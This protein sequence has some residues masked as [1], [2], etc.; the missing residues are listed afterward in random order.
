MKYY[1]KRILCTM[2]SA[3]LII[4]LAACT[5]QGSQTTQ[6]TQTTQTTAQTTTQTTTTEPMTID[7]VSFTMR[8]WDQVNWENSPL[9]L[10][11]QETFGLKLSVE[12]IDLEGYEEKFKIMFSTLNL[13]DICTW[14]GVSASDI[15]EAG[16][17]GIFADY[18]QYMDIMPNFRAICDEWYDML[19]YVTANSGALY[20]SPTYTTVSQPGYGGRGI[21]VRKDILDAAGFDYSNLES[22]DDLY[23]MF[24]VLKEGKDDQYV[25]G[26]DNNTWYI[27]SYIGVSREPGLWNEESQEWTANYMTPNCK[28]FVIFWANAFADGL[29]HPDYLNIGT[30]ELNQ[31]FYNGVVTAVCH[32]MYFLD[33]NTLGAVT[34]QE[35]THVLPP[36]YNGKKHPR[37]TTPIF[38][39]AMGRLVSGKLDEKV[40]QKIMRLNDWCYSMDGWK[41]TYLGIENED[42]IILSDDPF[43]TLALIES[44]KDK[45]PEAFKDKILTLE[46][47]STRRADLPT[48]LYGFYSLVPNPTPQDLETIADRTYAAN[49]WYA[50]PEPVV[51]LTGDELDEY[52]SLYSTID[53]YAKQIIAQMITGQLDIEAEWDKFLANLKDY[54]YDRLIELYN[55]GTQNFK[56]VKPNYQQ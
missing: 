37:P 38:D 53:D 25:I 5:P 48:N 12:I 34:E 49:G 26:R 31:H 22:L 9:D 19:P 29:L 1:W 14:R 2:I 16:D 35:W 17:R 4:G 7:E 6:P 54:G 8:S 51:T 24:T 30:S 33:N 23:E 50:K 32:G 10:Y 15:N 56:A 27:G 44:N 11:I 36:L 46:E 40:T 13:P 28:D 3:M 18:Y 47:S 21:G 41:R 52:N 43:K 45:I 42:Y 55:I 39:P 20:I